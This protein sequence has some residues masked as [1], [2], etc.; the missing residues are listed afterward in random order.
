[1]RFPKPMEG[2]H[3]LGPPSRSLITIPIGTMELYFH[4]VRNQNR[5][6]DLILVSF[7]FHEITRD[8]LSKK[9]K[10]EKEEG[11]KKARN[12]RS[13]TDFMKSLEEGNARY[14]SGGKKAK[15]GSIREYKTREPG[16]STHNSGRSIK[17]E[18]NGVGCWSEIKISS[19][20]RWLSF[21]S[22]FV[23]KW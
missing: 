3:F 10:K 19:T 15:F 14:Y 6:P 23:G 17:T 5:S 22:R 18:T 12:T 13:C 1:M 2:V 8:R 11:R 4:S 9:R 7:P 21:C 16:C 20:R